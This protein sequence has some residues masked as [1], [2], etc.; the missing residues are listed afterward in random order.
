ML[1]IIISY[2]PLAV[3]ETKAGEEIGKCYYFIWVK[4]YRFKFR[5][6]WA[7]SSAYLISKHLP[8]PP[9][10]ASREIRRKK[11]TET[12]PLTSPPGFCSFPLS[13]IS[14]RHLHR[15]R[16]FVSEGFASSRCRLPPSGRLILSLWW[17]RKSELLARV[18]P[19]RSNPLP[20]PKGPSVSQV[21]HI[22]PKIWQQ[23]GLGHR[24]GMSAAAVVSA[25][26]LTHPAPQFP[27]AELRWYCELQRAR[28]P[29]NCHPRSS[30]N[31]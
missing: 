21:R 2:I 1:L 14:K 10:H 11:K 23:R 24:F 18:V 22:T 20:P 25:R 31:T 27:C 12:K 30:C 9:A 13:F 6:P 3:L 8:K 15:K 29:I 26:R 4:L 5:S 28:T 16:I 19:A 7:R 17:L